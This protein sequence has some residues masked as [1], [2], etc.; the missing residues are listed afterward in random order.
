MVNAHVKGCCHIPVLCLSL[1]VCVVVRLSLSV[2]L[3]YVSSNHHHV[4]LFHALYS[5][6]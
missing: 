4:T 5:V 6:P 2:L 1:S 3:C